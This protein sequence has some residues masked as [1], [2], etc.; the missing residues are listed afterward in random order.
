MF[1]SLICPNLNLMEFWVR[2][3]YTM[4][5]QHHCERKAKNASLTSFME[6]MTSFEIKKYARNIYTYTIF[7]VFQRQLYVSQ[8]YCHVQGITNVEGDH[9]YEIRPDLW[10]PRTKIIWFLA[11]EV[12]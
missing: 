3:V 10:H 8:V 9:T 12:T 1:G 4:N 6:L 5:S 11:C 2:F 7:Y